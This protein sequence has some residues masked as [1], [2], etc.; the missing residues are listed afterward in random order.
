MI[1]FIKT[2]NA[3]N[4]VLKRGIKDAE[5]VNILF[6]SPYDKASLAILR[7]LKEGNHHIKDGLNVVDSF[8]TPHAFVA[9]DTTQVPCLINI[10]K[11]KKNIEYYVPFIYEKLGVFLP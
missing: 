11:R 6:T 3:F 9:C 2:E 5:T 4:K 8:D 1:N 10:Y 7:E